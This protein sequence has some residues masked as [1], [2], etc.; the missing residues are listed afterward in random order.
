MTSLNGFPDFH[1]A[2]RELTTPRP[3]DIARARKKGGPNFLYIRVST[4]GT[5]QSQLAFPGVG[6]DHHYA[7][8]DNYFV[9]R[10]AIAAK[11]LDTHALPQKPEDHFCAVFGGMRAI[12]RH[13][14]KLIWFEGYP[15]QLYDILAD[16]KEERNLAAT[17]PD[18]VATLAAE[19]HWQTS[20]PPDAK[21]ASG[22]RGRLERDRSSGCARAATSPSTSRRPGG[23]TRCDGSGCHRERDAA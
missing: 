11:W 21:A 14:S 3:G 1:Q 10:L 23:R 19:L 20:A 12:I 15:P 4:N 18:L 8:F 17:H 22:G 16:P 7:W 13:P 9:D 6:S 2:E 5:P